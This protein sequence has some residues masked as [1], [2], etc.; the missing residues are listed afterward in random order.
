[1]N[2]INYDNS[3]ESLKKKQ[4]YFVKFVVIKKMKKNDIKTLCLSTKIF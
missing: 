1:M 3:N 2:Y 4:L